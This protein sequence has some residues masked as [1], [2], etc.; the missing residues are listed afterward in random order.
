MVYKAKA[1]LYDQFLAFFTLDNN[2]CL[3]ACVCACAC[4]ACVR[5][6]RACACVCVGVRACVCACV[7]V[8][9]CVCVLGRGK[10]VIQWLFLP[11]IL[12]LEF[13]FSGKIKKNPTHRPS[14]KL[15]M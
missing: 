15:A 5:C 3:C 9:A 7:R 8:C 11:K 4:V 1:M 13:K 6:V 12:A 14:S 2:V 10:G